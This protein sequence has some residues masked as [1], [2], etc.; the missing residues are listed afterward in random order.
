LTG[1]AHNR[2]TSSPAAA[3]AALLR[4]AKPGQVVCFRSTI[5]DN[6]LE[7]SGVLRESQPDGIVLDTDSGTEWIPAQDIQVWRVLKQPPPI[8]PLFHEGP[9]V[10]SIKTTE[11]PSI[12]SPAHT[13]QPP[14]EVFQEQTS[15]SGKDVLPSPAD[16]ELFFAGDPG[17]SLPEPSFNIPSLPKDIQQEINRWKNRYDYAQKVREPARMS[18]DVARIAELADTLMEP[19]LY[20]LAGLLADYSGLGCSRVKTYLQ[21]SLEL[22]QNRQE[23]ATAIAAFAIRE[24]NWAEAVKFLI[25]AVRLDGDADKTN[26]V[27]NIG[28]CVLRLNT[29]NTPPIGLLLSSELPDAARR[30]ATNLVALVVKEDSAG[31]R[32]ALSG[33]MEQLRQTKIGNN[34]FPWRDEITAPVESRMIRRAIMPISEHGGTRRGHVSAYYPG[35]NFGFIVEETTGQTWFFHKTAVSSPSLLSALNGGKVRQDVT[36]SGN[37]E[38]KSGKYPLADSVSILSEESAIEDDSSKRAPLRLRL[39][40]IP[41]DGSFFAQAM[42]AE[43]LDQLDRA[44]GFYREEITRSA[45]HKKSAIKNLAALK[46]RKGEPDAAIALL[47]K[48]QHEFDRSEYTSLDQMRV[49]FRVK[50]RNF[51]EAA[52]LLAQL[53]KGTTSINKRVGYLRQEA[54]CLLASGD[55][56]GSIM[57]LESLLKQHPWDNASALLLEKAKN[58]KQTGRIPYD[59]PAGKDAAEYDDILSSLALGITPIAR[60]KLESCELRGIDAR[61]KESGNFSDQDVRQVQNLLDRVKGRRPRERADYL[62]TLAWLCEHASSVTGNSSVHMY[63]RR[64]FLALAEASFSDESPKDVVRCPNRRIKKPRWRDLVVS[65]RD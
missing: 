49:I 22:D 53:A 64:Y 61:T 11:G 41:K 31:Y 44:E 40:A 47:D 43:Q 20:F 62:L 37:V 60:Q 10:T 42:E 59:V 57:Q 33:S 8:P 17:M 5:S 65:V 38:A 12:S 55:F 30:L 51:V 28:Q 13:T 56:E 36:F 52:K 27:R 54:Y 26:L 15:H 39:Q 46:N 58:A 48:Y 2:E 16:L 6:A 24:R 3:F 63:L 18:Q 23:V 4:I 1:N 7:R 50:A 19:S 29:T 34:L 32:A 35:R 14:P 25:W 45:R 21:K 9:E